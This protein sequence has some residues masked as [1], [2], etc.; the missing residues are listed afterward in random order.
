MCCWRGRALTLTSDLFI[1]GVTKPRNNLV[2]RQSNN[3]PLD[4]LTFLYHNNVI[5]H[6]QIPTLR[7]TQKEC[8]EVVNFSNDDY[9]LHNW[10]N[11]TVMH[12]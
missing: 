6:K 10:L 8:N 9:A 7:M 4:Q 3:Q 5:K 2:G 12:F 11:I 1:S